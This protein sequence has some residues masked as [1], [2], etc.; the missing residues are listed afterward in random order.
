MSE[1]IQPSHIERDPR[2]DPHGLAPQALRGMGIPY[3]EPFSGDQL[4]VVVHGTQVVPVDGPTDSPA[5]V[6]ARNLVK[7]EM[8]STINARVRDIVSDLPERGVLQDD[9]RHGGVR[10]RD[11]MTGFAVEAHQDRRCCVAPASVV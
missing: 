4:V 1:K 3:G 8:D 6:L 7:S 11:R 2:G 9:V 5:Q 10:K